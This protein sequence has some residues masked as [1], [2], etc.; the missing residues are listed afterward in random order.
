MEVQWHGLV[1]V[2]IYIYDIYLYISIY[3]LLLFLFDV[4]DVLLFDVSFCGS[5]EPPIPLPGARGV[6]SQVGAPDH[7]EPGRPGGFS[8]APVFADLFLELEWYPQGIY[9]I[10][11]YKTNKTLGIYHHYE[12]NQQ[13]FRI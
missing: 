9:K 13:Y 5:V 4:F 12:L 8:M 7:V 3:I 10:G 1:S 2:Y 6:S 11:T